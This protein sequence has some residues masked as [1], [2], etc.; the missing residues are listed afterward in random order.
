M[1]ELRFEEMV[2]PSADLTQESPLPAMR[3]A[4]KVDLQSDTGDE[5]G[6]FIGYGLRPN[7]LPATLQDR[8]TSELR[9]TEWRTAV[10]E[11][12]Y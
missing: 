4:L 12:A 9:P 5:A 2:I 6:L 3:D 10:L 7:A 1:S 11:N 8:Y